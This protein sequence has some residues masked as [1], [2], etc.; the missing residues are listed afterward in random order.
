MGRTVLLILVVLLTG[1]CSAV[2][3]PPPAPAKGDVVPVLV[4]DYG[5]HSTLVLPR[6]EGGGLVEYAY[7]D[8]TYFGQN[9]KSV[10]TALHALLL[11]DQ[12][13]LGRR[14]LYV[15]PEESEL[16]AA[17]G[18]KAVV[19]FEAPREKVAEL[20]RALDERYSSRLDSITFSEVHHLYF[21]KDDERYGV[22]HNCNHFTAHGLEQLGCRVE[23]I[24]MMSGFR[25]KEAGGATTRPTTRPAGTAQS[26]VR[27]V[28]GNS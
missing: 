28:A 4:A 23:G 24:V 22:A 18:A 19:R 17:T 26:S 15:P 9:Q 7:G 11:S 21:V 16:A 12:A 20:E 27:R 6:T 13:T 3:V 8:W 5:Y 25:V 14:V 10:G 1:G 2:I